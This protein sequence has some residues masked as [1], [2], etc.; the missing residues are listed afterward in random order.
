MLYEVSFLGAAMDE[1][2]PIPKVK[3]RVHLQSVKND[4]L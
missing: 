1:N 2:V 4:V 3:V